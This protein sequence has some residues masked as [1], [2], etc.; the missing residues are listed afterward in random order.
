MEVSGENPPEENTVR[1][2]DGAVTDV[3]GNLAQG[4][5]S[6]SRR[7]TLIIEVGPNDLIVSYS[8]TVSGVVRYTVQTGDNTPSTV[9]NFLIF[10]VVLTY[11]VIDI[12]NQQITKGPLNRS[13][14][15]LSQFV[16]F[17]E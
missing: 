17:Q 3:S 8:I 1:I 14:I 2:E 4:Y 6:S 16:H 5:T 11:F 9:S 7:F 15:L 13:Y 12:R 10:D